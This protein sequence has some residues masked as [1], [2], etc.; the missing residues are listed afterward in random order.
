MCPDCYIP[1]RF[2]GQLKWQ[3]AADEL[4]I[5]DIGKKAM[6]LVAERLEELNNQKKLTEE[7]ISLYE[8]F[9]EC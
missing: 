5:F 3:K 9:V 1:L 7:H 6:A 2:T 4:K 8:K